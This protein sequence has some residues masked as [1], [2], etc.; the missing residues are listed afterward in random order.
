[1]ATRANKFFVPCVVMAGEVSCWVALSQARLISAVEPLPRRNSRRTRLS[2]ESMAM[3]TKYSPV[4]FLGQS[5]TKRMQSLDE[6]MEASLL[7]D[8]D[9]TPWI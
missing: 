6:A 2:R 7:A 4:G 5:R 8:V 9:K 1:M 3:E